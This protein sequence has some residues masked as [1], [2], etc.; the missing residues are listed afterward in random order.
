[1]PA[2]KGKSRVIDFPQSHCLSAGA[3]SE[4]KGAVAV[5]AKDEDEASHGLGAASMSYSIIASY[6]L[7][8]YSHNI[9]IYK[10]NMKGN[11]LYDE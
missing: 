10:F 7:E 6:K 5:P 3:F 11:N 9:M 2:K 8:P 1:M 4:L